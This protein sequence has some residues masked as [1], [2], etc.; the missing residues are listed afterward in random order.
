MLWLVLWAC[1]KASISDSGCVTTG[2]SLVTADWLCCTSQGFGPGFP[3]LGR[4]A[5][6]YCAVHDVHTPRTQIPAH[7]RGLQRAAWDA[8]TSLA[9]AQM[10]GP[11]PLRRRCTNPWD[12]SLQGCVQQADFYPA[13]SAWLAQPQ[14]ATYRN[15]I[16]FDAAGRIEIS[17]MN[18]L[19]T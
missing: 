4:A 1:R 5:P 19:H 13:L 10:K 2:L 11:A 7:L 12:S 17:Y 18:V 8:A 14:F 9:V 6:F 3:A 15:A 16:T